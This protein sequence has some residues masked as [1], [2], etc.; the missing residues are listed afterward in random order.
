MIKKEKSFLIDKKHFFLEKL[1]GRL[2][3][4]KISEPKIVAKLKMERQKWK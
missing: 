2:E 4:K 1:K 3:R